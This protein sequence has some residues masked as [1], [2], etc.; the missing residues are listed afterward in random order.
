MWE[1][2][3]ICS[4][5]GGLN[6]LSDKPVVVRKNVNWL[7]E[8]GRVYSHPAIALFRSLE[9]QAISKTLGGL[10]LF[11]P[12]L[13]LGCGEGW[14]GQ[15]LFESLVDVGLDTDEG[16]LERAA[17]TSRYLKLTL[18]DARNLPL[19]SG[20]FRTVFSNCVVEHIPEID[21]VLQEVSRVL[22]VGGLFV[23]TVPSE[24][25]GEFLWGYQLLT[26]WGFAGLAERYA[27]LRNRQLSHFHTYEAR[28]WEV[29]LAR[30]GLS[31]VAAKGYISKKS[32]RLWDRLAIGVLL[33]KMLCL[34]VA[35]RFCEDRMTGWSWARLKQTYQEDV[36]DNQGA[37]LLIVARKD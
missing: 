25:F 24:K 33:S 20:S 11:R 19:E 21:L 10:E 26:T 3:L 9:A 23:F 17:E 12:L 1:H 7:E 2:F 34:R 18:G 35:D 13:D 28:D 37:A 27:H 36:V 29:R 31:V 4:D 16:I 14:V 15:I 8:F 22:V 32:L 5:W 30:Y 6:I